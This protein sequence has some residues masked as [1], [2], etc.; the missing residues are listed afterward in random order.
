MPHAKA[1]SNKIIILKSLSI[2]WHRVKCGGLAG[3]EDGLLVLAEDFI[4]GVF[5]PA[6]RKRTARFQHTGGVVAG[7][8]V[9]G[10]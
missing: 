3:T 10:G 7:S 5:E 6:I 1:C 4:A 8:R 9:G 2:Q